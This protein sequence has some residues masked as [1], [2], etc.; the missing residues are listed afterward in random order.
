[1]NGGVPISGLFRK[2][3]ENWI[4]QGSKTGGRER[5][6]F[7]WTKI[8]AGPDSILLK[9]E[10]RNMLLEV[11]IK[12]RIVRWRLQTGHDWNWL[13]NVTSMN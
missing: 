10:S 9:D 12:N 6:T 8:S 1:M 11:D 3:G 13:Y 2:N 4:E 5:F 7:Y